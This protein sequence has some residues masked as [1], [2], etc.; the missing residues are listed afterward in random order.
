MNPGYIVAIFRRKIARIRRSFIFNVPEHLTYFTPATLERLLVKNNF[1]VHILRTIPANDDSEHL[2]FKGSPVI[3]IRALLF[4][5][6][7]ILNNIFDRKD[8]IFVIAQ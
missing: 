8:S 2:F 4:N 6:C 5:I 1:N 7:H 3:F